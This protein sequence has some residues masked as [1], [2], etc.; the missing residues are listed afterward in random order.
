M[1]H[2]RALG[3]ASPEMDEAVRNSERFTRRKG[4]LRKENGMRQGPEMSR[5]KVSLDPGVGWTICAGQC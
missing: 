5:F 3:N 4:I 2:L 1:L